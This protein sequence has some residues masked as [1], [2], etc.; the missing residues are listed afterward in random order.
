LMGWIALAEK[1]P[2]EAAGHFEEAISLL[3]A[4]RENSDEHA[5]YYDGLAAACYQAGDYAKAR[6]FYKKIISL[7]TGR[8]CCGD[9]YVR[10]HYW[11]G[12][13]CQNAGKVLEASGY[14]QTFLKFWQNA[15]VRMPEVADAAAQ[16]ATLR[17]AS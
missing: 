9:I 1:R 13:I 6:D 8:L 15:D 17:K 7:T 2:A 14:Y 10:A 5:F 3:P 4:Q 16:L 11:L 12:K